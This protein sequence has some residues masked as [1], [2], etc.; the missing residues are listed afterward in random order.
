MNN[1]DELLSS[2]SY[3]V[4]YKLRQACMQ[5]SLPLVIYLLETENNPEDVF[6]IDHIDGKTPLILASE[7]GNADIVAVLL[8]KGLSVIKNE[9]D[10]KIRSKFINIK[11][12]NGYTAMHYASHY[13]HTSVVS[14]LSYFDET[15]IEITDNN[16]RNALKISIQ[17]KSYD[18]INFLQSRFYPQYN[19]KLLLKESLDYCYNNT[20]SIEYINSLSIYNYII[21]IFCKYWGRYMSKK[22][23][24]RLSPILSYYSSKLSMLISFIYTIIFFY[25]SDHSKYGW[26]IYLYI[27]SIILQFIVI[28][29]MMRIYYKNPGEYNTKVIS[30]NTSRFLSYDD[31]IRALSKNKFNSG[32]ISSKTFCCHICRIYR[33]M[34]MGH[35]IYSGKC[36]PTYDHFCGFLWKD[37]GRNNYCEFITIISVMSLLAMPSFMWTS[38]LYNIDHM[39]DIKNFR[40]N[41]QIN[42]TIY[43]I[44]FLDIFILWTISMWIAIF[45]LLVYHIWCM[46]RGLTSREQANPTKFA[47]VKQN[48]VSL[49]SKDTILGN[50]KARLFPRKYDQCFS[51]KDID[52]FKNKSK[53]WEKRK[54]K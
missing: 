49:F 25:N 43:I 50:I 39:N 24:E 6:K 27:L 22:S 15:S 20:N 46:S 14:V 7:V 11:D 31:A 1:T 2:L 3:N 51:E 54:S 19:I 52:F 5:G 29:L 36:I 12:N 32:F 30:V 16:N 48:G 41:N 13:N 28:F 42:L 40:S 44:L 33:P 26:R 53:K 23:L 21:Y 38:I 8:I 45:T 37:I 47:F 4:L 10:F 9:K 35:S 34:R 17:M 18:T